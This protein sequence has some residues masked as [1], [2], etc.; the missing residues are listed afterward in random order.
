[1]GV[2]P[3]KDPF[4]KPISKTF[5]DFMNKSMNLKDAVERGC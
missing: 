2:K 3:S 5:V 4:F 1:M